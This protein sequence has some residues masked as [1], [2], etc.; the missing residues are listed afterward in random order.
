[1]I[2]TAFNK[3]RFDVGTGHLL[4]FNCV[5]CQE[6]NRQ[7]DLHAINLRFDPRSIVD[8]IGSLSLGASILRT[9]FLSN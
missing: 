9:E 5:G 7:H 2:I 8:F 1:M 3:F 4:L 6:A